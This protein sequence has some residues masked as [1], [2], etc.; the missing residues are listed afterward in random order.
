M[1]RDV[2]VG[3]VIGV[4]ILAI[5]IIAMAM[6]DDTELRPHAQVANAVPPNFSSFPGFSETPATG[7]G[8]P[9]TAGATPMP[10]ATGTGS[11]AETTRPPDA[12]TV[13]GETTAPPAGTG[14]T[15]EPKV[16]VV[17]KGNTLWDLGVKY[18]GDGT[19]GKLI[20]QAN[21]AV[22]PNPEVLRIGQKLIIPPA[23]APPA[24]AAAPAAAAVAGTKH[25][26]TRNDTLWSL[27]QKY[28]GDGAKWKRILQANQDLIKDERS[29]PVGKTIVIPRAD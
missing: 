29:L 18:Y 10:P 4:A 22:I 12:G 5:I 20:L 21:K 6:Q 15:P 7:V 11:V 8:T 17:E 23:V 16:H 13:A 28:Y 19:K 27:A 14:T 26:L 9:P 24:P 3:L 25:T 1:Q 2:K